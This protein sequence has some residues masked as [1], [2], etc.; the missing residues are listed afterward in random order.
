MGAK[1]ANVTPAWELG[2]IKNAIATSVPNQSS[3]PLRIA[4]WDEFKKLSNL[5]IADNGL[6]GS[7]EDVAKICQEAG[8]ALKTNNPSASAGICFAIFREP[9]AKE[10]LTLVELGASVGLTF[11]VN[12]VAI[13]LMAA[14]WL[15]EDAP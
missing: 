5:L 1:A 7:V 12:P 3:E 2:L 9:C 6:N 11:T 4:Y 13:N 8:L 14:P 15:V 10:L